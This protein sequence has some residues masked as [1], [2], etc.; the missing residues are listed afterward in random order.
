MA[1]MVELRCPNDGKLLM[2]AS[3][4]PGLVVETKCSRCRET[5]TAS[6]EGPAESE[7]G[8]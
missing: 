1:G 4:V 2:K 5:I 8:K 6:L 3:E 7:E